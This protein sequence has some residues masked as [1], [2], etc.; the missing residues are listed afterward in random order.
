MRNA[1]DEIVKELEVDYCN[2]LAYLKEE[3]TENDEIKLKA[4][5]SKVLGN[6]E[7]IT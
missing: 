5:E 4:L 3:E 1:I 6:L 2:V 7:R